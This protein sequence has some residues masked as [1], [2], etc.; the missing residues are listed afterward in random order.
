MKFSKKWQS[1]LLTVFLMFNMCFVFACGT[2]SSSSSSSDV[3]GQNQSSNK[4]NN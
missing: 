2:D 1:K 3:S 4:T